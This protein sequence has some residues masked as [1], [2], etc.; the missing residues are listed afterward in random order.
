MGLVESTLMYGNNGELVV[1]LE[2]MYR[3]ECPSDMN[4]KME[5][6][7]KRAVVH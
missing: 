5:N 4:R 6:L 1:E 2:A 3:I 7:R